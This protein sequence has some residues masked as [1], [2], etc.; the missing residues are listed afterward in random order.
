MTMPDFKTEEKSTGAVNFPP[1]QNH[2]TFCFTVYLLTFQLSE[3]ESRQLKL[4]RT[5][6]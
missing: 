4:A 5:D 2:T 6:N 3:E 1:Q